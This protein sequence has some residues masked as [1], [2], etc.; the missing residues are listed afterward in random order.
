MPSITPSYKRLKHNYWQQ[1]YSSGITSPVWTLYGGGTLDQAGTYIAPSAGW[2]D[3]FISAGTDFW[4]GVGPNVTLNPDDS[5][6]VNTPDWL[7]Q[8]AESFATLTAPGDY[9]E[10]RIY[11]PSSYLLMVTDSTRSKSF[12]IYSGQYYEVNGGPPVFGSGFSLAVGDMMLI[13]RDGTKL[14]LYQ[15]GTLVATSLYDFDFPVHLEL[16]IS[17]NIPFG[18]H[19]Q[20]PS[21]GGPGLQYYTSA[22]AHVF[23]EPAVPLPLEGCELYLDAAYNFTTHGNPVSVLPDISGNNRNLTASASQ[24]TLQ[25]NVLNTRPVVRFNSSDPLI[26]STANF[27]VRC[28]FAVVKYD[29]PYFP[30]Y[31]GLL[32]G[33]NN[34]AVLVGNIYD[35]RWFDFLDPN[36][37][38]RSNDRI[39]PINNAPA[40]M[41]QFR[42]V[43]FRYWA[44]A[45]YMDGVQLGSD[46]NFLGRKWKGDVAMLALYSRDFLEEE[47]RL[48]SKRLADAYALTLADVYP[49]QADSAELTETPLQT[50]NLYDPPEGDRI[51]EVLDTPRRLLN[52]SFSAAN[53]SE[54]RTMKAF[55]AAHYP[56]V[57]CIYRDYRFTPPEDILGYIDSPYEIEGSTNEFAYAFAFRE[58]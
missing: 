10:V 36:V 22:T 29:G 26:N 35:T 34:A 58:K 6:T 20:K 15:N 40:P 50:V 5:L 49:Y 53:Q 25:T 57:P 3:V 2:G 55:H 7:W 11:D 41:Q 28:G 24:P 13:Q 44:G 16:G 33:M 32:T 8:Q 52:L 30:T 23:I 43:F 37:E 19:I 47:I 51:V 27:H 17:A 45:M 9:F 48:Y 14:K 31:V 56:E 18:G 38:I 42:I 1:F 12:G 39:H 4:K 21:A 46:R 54:V